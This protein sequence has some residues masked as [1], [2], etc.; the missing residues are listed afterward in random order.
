MQCIGAAVCA[1]CTA[2]QQGVACDRWAQPRVTVRLCLGAEPVVLSAGLLQLPPVVCSLGALCRLDLSQNLLSALPASIR[3]LS[4]L[5]VPASL[6]RTVLYT[7]C[8]Y[9]EAL[10]PP[11]TAPAVGH[12]YRSR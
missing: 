8:E 12:L 9:L 11:L 1:R 3:S 5:G 6:A 7:T 10:P 2:T 4:A